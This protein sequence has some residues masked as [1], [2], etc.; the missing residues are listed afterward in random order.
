MDVV[1][2]YEWRVTW[3]WMLSFPYE[4]VLHVLVQPMERFGCYQPSM[5][6]QLA[7]KAPAAYECWISDIVAIRAASWME[8]W[9]EWWKEESVRIMADASDRWRPS[10]RSLERLR[11]ELYRIGPPPERGRLRGP[12]HAGLSKME[13]AAFA[14]GAYDRLGQRDLPPWRP[15]VIHRAIGGF[16]AGW[17]GVGR[18]DTNRVVGSR[19]P[20][21]RARKLK[22]R[23]RRPRAA[24]PSSL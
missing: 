10:K 18:K 24:G 19:R 22:R 15:G 8:S 11:L 3:E 12:S 21:V 16:W 4:R 14:T 23:S 9:A 7:A 13:E 2:D 1:V 6:P 17:Y 5:T 20:R